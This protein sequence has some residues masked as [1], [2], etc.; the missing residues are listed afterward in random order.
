LNPTSRTAAAAYGGS[1]WTPRLTTHREE[2]GTLWSAYGVANEWEPLRAVLLH[3]PG[4]ELAQVDDPD[5]SLML[6]V[7]DAA[8]AAGQHEGMAEA[9]RRQGVEVH[10]VDPIETPSPNQMFV[11]DL[12]L[13][14][15]EGAIV[16][17][18][19]SSVR[20]GEE[21]WVARRLADL[22]VPI[23]R[24]LSGNATFEGADAIWLGAERVL[25]GRGLRTNPEGAR[26]VAEALASVGAEAVQVDL[27][28]GAMHMMGQVRIVD[29]DLAL[30]QRGRTPWSAVHALRDHGY[31]VYFFPDEEEIRDGFAH[32]FVTLGPRRILMPAGNPRSQEFYEVLGIGCVT[33]QVD[34][35]AKAAGAIGCL[36]G[37]LSRG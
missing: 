37:V 36:S 33:V 17:R 11:A 9:Y 31:E 27:P 7:P 12:M 15:P 26:Q 8:R 5:A 23:L 32:N 10:H 22:G 34:E 20:A 14:T 3:R 28:H 4:A 30:I 6:E 2:I 1:Q 35:L 13:M 18:P 16:A 21:R 24:T 29:R 19:A 25:I